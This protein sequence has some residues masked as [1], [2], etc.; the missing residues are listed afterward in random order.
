MFHSK[1]TRADLDKISATRPIVVLHRSWHEI[2]LNTQALEADNPL[3]ISA[4]KIKDIKI[5][6]TVHEGRKLPVQHQQARHAAPGPIPDDA[7]IKAMELD[8]LAHESEDGA[9]ADVC[10]PNKVF[11][12]A[13]STTR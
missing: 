3:T 9:H 2:I 11:A 7:S 6:G 5:W 10:M 8:M 4:A 1:L 12:A 13:M